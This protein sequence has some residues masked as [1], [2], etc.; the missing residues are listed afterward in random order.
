MMTTQLLIF[1]TSNLHQASWQALLES[2][3]GIVVEGAIGM[4]G[5][6][7]TFSLSH[8]RPF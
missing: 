7:P 4:L 3:P 2:Q 5:Q 6:I 1:A 8:P